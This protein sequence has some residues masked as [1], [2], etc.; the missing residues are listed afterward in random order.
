MKFTLEKSESD[1]N[2]RAGRLSLPHGEVL[3]PVFMPVGTNSTVKTLT[4]E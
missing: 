2:A 1:Y 4:M 3:T